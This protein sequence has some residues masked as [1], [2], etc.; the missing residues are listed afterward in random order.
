MGLG[1]TI[2]TA[3][4]L[5]NI[6]CKRGPYLIVAPL[7]TVVQWQREISKWTD[8]NVVLYTGNAAD[9]AM[10]LE[11]EFAYKDDRP[12]KLKSN[13]K[14]LKNCHNNRSSVGMKTWMVQVV[15]TTPE[16]MLTKDRDELHTID[17][18]MLIVDEAHNKLK[19]RTSKFS[20]SVQDKK[21]LY[22]HCLLLTGTPIQNNLDELWSLLN[23][24]DPRK[25]ANN[26]Y[27]LGRYGNM[28][29][30]KRV[31]ELLEVIRPY[32]LRRLK[33]DVEK[34]LPAKEETIIKVE[35]TTLQKKYYRA[36]YEKNYEFLQQN[37][38]RT[39]TANLLMELRKCANHPFLL[40]GVEDEAKKNIERKGLENEAD[41]LVKSSGKLVLLDKFLPKLKLGGHRVL[42]F[43]QFRI[44]L[45]IIEDYLVLREFQ[46]ERID[47]SITGKLRQMAIDKFQTSKSSFIMLLTTKAGGVGEFL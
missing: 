20:Q 39:H 38:S 35:L 29:G 8:L 34:D 13:Q 3:A 11:Y 32:I 25:F 44:M 41:F 36:L 19:S 21:F 26:S 42:I 22:R 47:G 37:Q 23:V 14:Y 30:K 43:S 9:R 4:F 10:I 6:C 18:E 7:S 33:E 28:R 5:S 16:I 40:E 27:F 24:I 1:K 17:W 12:K 15:I 31:D 2:Q 45:D 46:F